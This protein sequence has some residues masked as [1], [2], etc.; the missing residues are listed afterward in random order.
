MTIQHNF[1]ADNSRNGWSIVAFDMVNKK[2]VQV[3]AYGLKEK[4]FGSPIED[5]YLKVGERMVISMPDGEVLYEITKISYNED[6]Y[7]L[8]SAELVY[9][10]HLSGFK[11]FALSD[12]GQRDVA[13]AWS[14]AKNKNA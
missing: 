6:P 11:I 2:K 10:Q 3:K 14:A 9:V 7:D 8:F 12:E 5:G 1:T 13:K 4:L